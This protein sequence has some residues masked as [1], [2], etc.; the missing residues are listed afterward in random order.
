MYRP[1]KSAGPDQDWTIMRA[2][3]FAQHSRAV[4]ETEVLYSDKIAWV[5]LGLTGVAKS[6]F[7]RLVGSTFVHKVV[8]A[9]LGT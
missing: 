4:P 1:G 7:R 8:G 5:L 6:L 2:R 3:Q 9:I